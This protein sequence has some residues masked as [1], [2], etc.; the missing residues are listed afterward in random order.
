[1]NKRTLAILAATGAAVIYGL[2]HTIAKG[3]MPKYVQPFGFIFLR[4]TGAMILFWLVSL[5]TPKERI[6]RSDWWRLLGCAVGGMSLNMLAFFKGLS[7]STPVYSSVLSTITPI[8]VFIL[9][10]FLIDEK[11]TLR[12]GLGILLGFGGALVLVLMGNETRA[13]APN[14]FL[15][16]LLF[17]F[18][19]CIFGVYLILVK[20]LTQK[21]STI[22]LM[23]YL[24]LIG[25]VINLPVT[26]GEF[27]EIDWQNMPFE[28]WWKICFVVI[29]T[30]FFTYLLNVYAMRQLAASTIGAFIYLQPLIAIVYA[31]STGYGTLSLDKI[32]GAALVFSGVYLV[33]QKK[34]HP[35]NKE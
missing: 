2:N 33:T 10:S 20:P 12:K 23:K 7:Y 18:N 21:Y 28:G 17:I 22:T 11:M 29:G 26:Y 25:F 4:V 19:A 15:G 9:S 1:M 5:F 3:V 32:T 34:K 27:L 6:Q 16:N 24:F 8:L 35:V 31:V 13:D 14:I 30:T